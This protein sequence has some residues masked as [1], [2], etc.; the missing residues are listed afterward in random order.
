MNSKKIRDQKFD[1]LLTPENAAFIAIDYQP[2]QVSSIKSMDQKE[3]VNN[4]TKTAKLAKIFKLPTVLSTVNVKSGENE[5]QIKEIEEIFPN[6]EPVDR[7]TIN[8]WEDE[9]FYEAVKKIGR[10]KLIITA[11]WTEAC[12][13][14]PALDALKEGYEVYVVVDAVGGTSKLAH[15]VALR[16][17]EQA[18]A[19]LIS[20]T[21]LACELQRDWNRE[22][23]KEE[24]A[25][26]LFS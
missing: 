4:I 1:H 23:T 6:I 17:M 8:S 9:E 24:F 14:F 13:S 26:I 16:R 15:K 21:Q 12:L 10:K 25:K 5:P 7:T 20:F 11:L 3:L 18:G 19:K 2:I 22:E